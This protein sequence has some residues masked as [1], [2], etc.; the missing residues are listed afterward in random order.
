MKKSFV[1]IMIVLVLFNFTGICH[2]G[3]VINQYSNFWVLVDEIED[4]MI[5]VVYGQG[6]KMP[7]QDFH[8]MCTNIAREVGSLDANDP[9]LELKVQQIAIDKFVE[10]IKYN[11]YQQID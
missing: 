7:E 4:T 2:A 9:A 1:I 8:A 3:K 11:G 6:I 10:Y 5:Q